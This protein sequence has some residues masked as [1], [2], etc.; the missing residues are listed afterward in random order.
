MKIIFSILNKTFVI[1]ECGETALRQSRMC[2]YRGSMDSRLKRAGMTYLF[3]ALIIFCCSVSFAFAALTE[4][5]SLERALSN[6]VA[7][8][9]ELTQPR[10]VYQTAP[11]RDPMQP[12][13]DDQGTMM[14]SDEISD[15]LLLQGIFVSGGTKMI[16]VD[17][18]I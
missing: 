7:Q 1:P 15:G 5:E 10:R 14:H 3:S 9:R 11:R 16:L 2:F 8:F 17:D 6:S 4:N 13:I 18:R 12:L